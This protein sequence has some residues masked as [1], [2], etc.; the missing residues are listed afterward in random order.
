[1]KD[2]NISILTFIKEKVPYLFNGNEKYRKWPESGTYIKLYEEVP[3][4]TSAINFI[5]NNLIIQGIEEI[6]FWNLQKLALDYL[7]FGGFTYEIQKLR[8]GGSKL[9]Y[10]DIGKCRLNPDKTKIGYAETWENYKIDVKWKNISEN[11]NKDGIYYF[12]NNKSRYDYPTPYYFSAIK[13]LDTMSHIIDYHNNNAKGGFSP[14]VVIN[15][16]NGE[17]DADTKKEIEKKI[18]EKFTGSSGQKFILSFNES[19]T[20]K[21]TIEKLEND[22]LDQKFE[23]LQK[24]IQNQIIIAHQITSGQLIGVKSES[25]GFAEIEYKESLQIFLDV[26]VSSFRRELEFALSKMLNKEIKL[27]E[28]APVSLSKLNQKPNDLSNINQNTQG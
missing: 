25:Q 5:L 17:P 13:S 15:F 1:M 19:D 4:H 10:L 24:F 9:N 8:G 2:N 23:T 18:T 26:V 27:A 20:T 7:I 11:I 22:N 6:D 14:S 16:N 28:P 21:T 3:E 12:K